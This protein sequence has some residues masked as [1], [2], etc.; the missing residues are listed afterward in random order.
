M[1]KAVRFPYL[2]AL[3]REDPSGAGKLVAY[4]HLR[5]T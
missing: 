5:Q 1:T 3:A 4:L 2:P